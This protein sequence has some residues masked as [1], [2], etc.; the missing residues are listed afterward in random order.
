MSRYK[1]NSALSEPVF[2]LIAVHKMQMQFCTGVDGHSDPKLI[3][4]RPIESWCRAS[5]ITI[6]Y[7]KCINTGR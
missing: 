7:E 6:I 5:K 1:L 2:F 4:D 3:H